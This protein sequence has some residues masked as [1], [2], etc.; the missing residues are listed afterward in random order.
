LDKIRAVTMAAAQVAKKLKDKRQ[1]RTMEE[2]FKKVDKDGNGSISLSEY[3]GIFE[4]HGIVVNKTETNRVIRLAGD[5]G[6][7]TKE[8]FIKILKSSDFFMKAFDKNKDGI[9]TETE[10]M[11][12]AELAFHALDKDGSGYVTEKE[13]KKLSKKLST[14]ELKS[15]MTKL[16][17]DGDGRLS[18]E[19]FRVLFE[20]AERRKAAQEKPT[21]PPPP[22]Q[23]K[24]RHNS[25]QAKSSCSRHESRM[26]HHP[27]ARSLASNPLPTTLSAP[28]SLSEATS[29]L[30]EL[31]VSPR[32]QSQRQNF[33]VRYQMV[34]ACSTQ[35]PHR[36][37]HKKSDGSGVKISKDPHTI[38]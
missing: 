29:S 22:T 27:T 4:E 7:L 25:V 32:G 5:D 14:N 13:L 15:L 6:N 26:S 24:A 38:E 10:M 28:S 18:F 34:R 16:D 8:S 30:A 17:S 11:T 21:A 1:K 35:D 36:I 33:K 31:S 2:I 9:V 12:R 37:L 20:N 23:L 3:F 19:E